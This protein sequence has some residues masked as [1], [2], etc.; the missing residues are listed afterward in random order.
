M[1]IR[2]ADCEPDAVKFCRGI[3]LAYCFAFDTAFGRG[4]K[5]HRS[6]SQGGHVSFRAR[7]SGIGELRMQNLRKALHH[8]AFCILNSAF[9]WSPRLVSRQRLLGFSE[10]LICLSYSGKKKL[11]APT[12]KLQRSTKHQTY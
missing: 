8:S 1:Q 2:E 10:A 9:K 11:Q 4:E 6:F 3:E 7:Q 12:T 5:A